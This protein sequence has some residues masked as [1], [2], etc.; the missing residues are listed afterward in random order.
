MT[1][2]AGE[3]SGASGF[4]V[5][6]LAL[7]VLFSVVFLDNLGFAIVLPYLFFYAQSLGATAFEYGAL[8][9][10]YSLLS[11]VFTPI[12]ARL[13]D[14]YGRRRII[15]VALIVSST[16]YFAFGTAQVLWLLFFSRALAGTTAATGLSG[17]RRSA[18]RAT[19][20]S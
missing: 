20:R 18:G 7:T 14:R 3:N 12:V 11:F 4:L 9:A 1:V 6:R 2:L 16:S 8:L 17:A 15:L 5:N 13:S 19:I 10:S